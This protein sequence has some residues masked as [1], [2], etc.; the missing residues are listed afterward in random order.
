M[1]GQQECNCFYIS[2]LQGAHERQQTNIE[3]DAIGINDC[4]SSKNFLM[5]AD[6]SKRRMKFIIE[7]TTTWQ[8]GMKE[9]FENQRKSL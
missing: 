1:I 2:L 5:G 9:T 8:L 6:M 3:S 7:G 4:A